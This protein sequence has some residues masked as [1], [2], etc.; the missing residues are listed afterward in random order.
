[1]VVLVRAN[2]PAI[3]EVVIL[4]GNPAIHQG[5]TAKVASKLLLD[6]L[7]GRREATQ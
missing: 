6:T 5:R 1:L 3:H 2:G 7:L 4:S